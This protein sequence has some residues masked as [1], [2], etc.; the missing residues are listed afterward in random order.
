MAYGYDDEFVDHR[1]VLDEL[2]EQIEQDAL[3]NDFR[4]LCDSYDR[5]HG[6]LRDCR[7]ST[8]E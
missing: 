6:L 1:T 8:T 5:K 3:D 7:E 4:R 2:E